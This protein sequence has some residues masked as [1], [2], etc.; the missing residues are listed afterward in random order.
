MAFCPNSDENLGAQNP[1]S[2][3][4]AGKIGRT[5]KTIGTGK[6]KFHNQPEATKNQRRFQAE[7]S[8]LPLNVTTYQIKCFEQFKLFVFSYL[9]EGSFP[10]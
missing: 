8:R 10:I 2:H 6:D 4:R 9:V 5:M 7:Y 1:L 3:H